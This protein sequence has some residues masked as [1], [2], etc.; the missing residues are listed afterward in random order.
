MTVDRNA[1]EQRTTGYNTG[2]ASG[3]TTDDKFLTVGV[4]PERQARKR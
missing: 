2:F 1:D 4:P 3:G